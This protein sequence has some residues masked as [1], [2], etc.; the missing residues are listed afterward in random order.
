MTMIQDMRV[1]SNDEILAV[2]SGDPQPRAHRRGEPQ[3]CAE[4]RLIP[5]NRVAASRDCSYLT[6]VRTNAWKEQCYVDREE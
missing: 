6:D 5:G 4:R 3:R 1:L 2:P